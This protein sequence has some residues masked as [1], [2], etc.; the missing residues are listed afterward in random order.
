[1]RVLLTKEYIDYF[2]LKQISKDI[3]KLFDDYNYKVSVAQL[4]IDCG[5]HGE[6]SYR[7]ESL[8]KYRKFSSVE[9]AVIK[10]EKLMKYIDDFNVKIKNL[11]LTLT[12]DELEIFHY[13]VEER[14]TD[15]ELCDRICKSYKTYYQIKK[16]CFVKIA[17]R[18]NL[19]REKEEM[20]LETISLYD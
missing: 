10:R 2:D 9:Q 15:K 7:G 14:E 17:L 18:F 13:A 20:I 3:L 4:Y 6:L 1:M 19:V 16:S 12:D 11:K 5:Q 8:S